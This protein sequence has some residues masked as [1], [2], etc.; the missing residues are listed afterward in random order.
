MG[1]L[2][3]GDQNIE[4]DGSNLAGGIYYYTL[5]TNGK[6]STKKFAVAK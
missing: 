2:G 3:A 4:F 1:V 5:T 6:R